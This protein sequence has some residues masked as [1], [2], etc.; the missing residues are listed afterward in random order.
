MIL[1]DLVQ[2]LV[3]G[4]GWRFIASAAKWGGPAGAQE[5]VKKEKGRAA[6]AVGMKREG[7]SGAG[8]LKKIKV[9]PKVK[10][11]GWGSEE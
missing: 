3:F 9:E 8:G 10:S 7:S 5:A 11:D 1:V 4:F 2:V 6:G